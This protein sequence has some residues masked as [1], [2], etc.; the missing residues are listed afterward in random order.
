MDERPMGQESMQTNYV[1]S[2]E[3]MIVMVLANYYY[4][5]GRGVFR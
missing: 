3:E 4:D 1:G 2:Q 5:V